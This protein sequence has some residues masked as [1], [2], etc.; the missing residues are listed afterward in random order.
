MCEGG[1]MHARGFLRG[2]SWLLFS[3]MPWASVWAESTLAQR[4]EGHETVARA[5]FSTL[6]FLA[7][8]LFR[9]WFLQRLCANV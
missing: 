6:A 3:A 8:W 4:T 2:L 7:G 9:W 5:A 1:M